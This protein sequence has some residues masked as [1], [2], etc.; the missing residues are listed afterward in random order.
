MLFAVIIDRMARQKEHIVFELWFFSIWLAVSKRFWCQAKISV[1]LI[2]IT[3]LPFPGSFDA[4]AETLPESVSQCVGPY[5]RDPSPNPAPPLDPMRP[6]YFDIGANRFAIPWIYLLGRPRQNM[7]SCALNSHPLGVKFR[8]SVSPNQEQSAQPYDGSSI[9]DAR[10]SDLVEVDTIQHYVDTPERYYDPALRY[11]N[12]KARLGPASSSKVFD[13]IE[14]LKWDASSD[15]QVSWHFSNLHTEVF[16]TCV[17]PR[18]CAGFID[19][20]DRKLSARI[21]LDKSAV[22]DIHRIE[23][24]LRSLLT[25]WQVD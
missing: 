7:P 5:E 1:V 11:A 17:L 15:D 25:I 4:F 16:L 3:V 22:P 14:Q 19:F 21:V 10:P 23:S 9:G 8:Y 20:R 13:G 6:F 2:A 18:L 24:M 12:F